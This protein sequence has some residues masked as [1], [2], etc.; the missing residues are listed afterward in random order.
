[1]RFLHAL[2]LL[3]LLAPALFAQGPGIV[4]GFPFTIAPDDTLRSEHLPG[5]PP[6][7][8]G[9]HGFLQSDG[10]GGFRFAD[11]TPARF[12]GVNLQ[13]DACLP[14]SLQAVTTAGRLAKLGVNLVRFEY[15]DNG[16]DWAEQLSILDRATGFRT[17]HPERMRRFDRFVAELKKRG[18]YSWLTLH[19]A[20]PLRREDGLGVLADSSFWLGQG[21][22]YLYPQAADAHREITRQLLEHVNPFTGKAYREDPAIAML[23]ILNKGSLLT[24][25]RLNYTTFQ[26]GGY[27]FTWS[28]SRRLDTLYSEFL[29]RKYGST[30]GL[31]TAWRTT[32]PTGG[33]PNRIREGSFEGDFESIWSIEA[34]DGPTIS[35]IL[36]Q[37]DSVPDGDLS[38]T[39]R[40]RNG[41]GNIYNARMEQQVSLDY[42]K[43]YRLSFRAKCSN[44][45]GRD[46]LLVTYGEGYM[47]SGLNQRVR[48]NPWWTTHQVEF[49]TP[50]Q[51]VAHLLEFYMGDVDGDISI[52]DIQ[53]REIAPGGLLPNEDLAI[54]AVARI[55]WNND[56][57]YLLSS[58]RVEDQSEF[59]IDL[60]RSY[61]DR[62]RNF[63]SDTLGAR[64]PVTGAQSYWAS[65]FME[66]VEQGRMDFSAAMAGWDWIGQND[67]GEW[68][69]RNYSPLRQTGYAGGIYE[70]AAKAHIAQPFVAT[71]STPFPNRYQAESMM[72]LGAYSRLNGWDGLV[73]DTYAGSASEYNRSSI[74]SGLYSQFSSNPVML[75]MMPVLSQIVRNGLLKSSPLPT[76]IQHT[77]QQELIYP[78]MEWA[79]NIFGMPGGVPG[80]A[81]ASTAIGI[82]SSEGAYFTQRTDIDFPE[83]EGEIRSDTREINWEY[84]RGVLS[85]NSPYVQ[86]ASGAIGRAGGI[87]LDDMDIDLLSNNETATVIWSVADSGEN[88]RGTT[89]GDDFM[90][91]LLTIVSRTEPTGWSWADTS[92][93]DR[94]GSGPMLIDPVRVRLTLRTNLDSGINLFVAPL[95]ST[96]KPTSAG[97]IVRPTKTD[98][99]WVVDIDQSKTPALWYSISW[100][101]LASAPAAPDKGDL[102]LAAP[103]GT[104]GDLHVALP[105]H[106]SRVRIELFDALGRSAKL[107]H[108]GSLDAGERSIFLDRRGL[109]TGVYLVRLTTEKGEQVVTRVVV[110]R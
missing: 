40:L 70:L 12:F 37:G 77:R 96:G 78:R 76:R 63:I 32:E 3:P 86:G 71:F 67:A 87:R 109:A 42:N 62:L 108:N 33:F 110:V 66:A 47:V 23:E 69:L 73:F 28:Q 7:E 58:K 15:F 64:Q 82:D 74:D 1:M 45:G 11:G 84:L 43:L 105:G 31:A 39:M 19:S 25:W 6:G 55:P 8:A 99:G 80:F 46:L 68:M 24:L 26:P 60:E 51:S 50:I 16:Y 65:G 85:I 95:D 57:N 81:M 90:K 38:L 5:L 20:R 14:D 104:G 30:A 4:N 101:A 103:V 94:W 89:L 107:L 75:A 29:R 41:R 36:M 88:V 9:V 53:L 17:L 72:M 52:D 98:D 83:V 27:S 92:R 49:L 91:S 10:D 61:Y 102:T 35:E 97:E 22:Y 93:A 34:Y 59:Y 2:L 13:W 106:R 56:A 48:L 21:M 79:W 18:I 54:S 44:P 100:G